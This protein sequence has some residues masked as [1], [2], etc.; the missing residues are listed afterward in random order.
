MLTK[1][2]ALIVMG[3][4]FGDEGKGK[5]VD[6]LSENA[7]LV[8]RVQGGNN[9]G[10][11]IYIGTQKIVTHLLP[12]GVLRDTCQVAIGSG[13]VIDPLVLFEEFEKVRSH[14]ID[15]SPERIH[16]DGRAHIIL[17]YHKIMDGKR[18]SDRA[19]G[20]TAIGTTGRG[21]GPAYASRAYREGLRVAEFVEP[22]SFEKYLQEHPTMAEGLDENIKSQYI[23][24]AEFL[25]PYV[26]DAALLT[27]EKLASGGR[28]L[29]EGA[30]GALLDPSYGTYPFVTSSALFSGAAA[31]GIGIAPQRIGDIIGV[32]KAYS[33]RV[34]N[35][36]FPGELSGTLEKKLRDVGK[37]FGSTT[38]R[39]RRVGWLDLVALRYMSLTNGFTSLALMKS[40]VLDG[41]EYVGAITAYRDKRSN[42][43][44]KSWPMSTDDWQFVDPV[45]EFFPGWDKLVLGPNSLHKNFI[46]YMET[47]ELYAKAK[48]CFISTGPARDEG[49][50]KQDLE[51]K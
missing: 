8:A 15:L 27:C 26:K 28:V 23:K 7:D 2:K 37:E 35:G 24:I 46:H 5:F 32:I 30:Q 39:P 47:I 18:E 11:T 40:D 22:S 44:M 29:I 51:K 45:V 31:G 20:G 9:A 33:T 50:W 21:I 6:V 10:H 36:P 34:G 1:G 13:V 14:G 12:I 19:K 25:K 49:V 16:I 17:P 3:A 4:Q 38:G 41:F 48:V 42:E 43:I